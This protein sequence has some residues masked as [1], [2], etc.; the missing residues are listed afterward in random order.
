METS[1]A[2]E[3]ERLSAAVRAEGSK[4]ME[5]RQTAQTL[6]QE[7]LRLQRALAEDE[8]S[9][10]V[11]VS[12]GDLADVSEDELVSCYLRLA[13]NFKTVLGTQQGLRE[14]VQRLRVRVWRE[15]WGCA[16]A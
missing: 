14:D 15:E 12:V 13:D 1:L 4:L 2:H 6:Q 9:L 7:R 5:Q 3:L 8:A 11:D 16:D 10:H